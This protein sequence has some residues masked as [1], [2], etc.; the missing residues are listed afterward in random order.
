M[1]SAGTTKLWI[2]VR[3]LWINRWNPFSARVYR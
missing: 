1:I 2:A 3:W